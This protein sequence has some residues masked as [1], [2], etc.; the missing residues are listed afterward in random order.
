M[1]A[2]SHHEGA[3]RI[4]S[5]VTAVA[6]VVCLLLHAGSAPAQIPPGTHRFDMV[7]QPL[8]SALAEFA[9]VSGVDIAYRQSLAA[10]RRSRDVHGDYTAPVALQMLLEGTG[11]AARFTGPR[12]AIIFEPGTSEVSAPRRGTSATPSLRLGMA[13]VRA[14]VIVGTRNRTGHRQYAMVVQSEVR[15]WLRADRA[16]QGR[17][18]RLEIG[19]LVDPHGLIRQV[20]VR[21]PSSEAAW[22]EHVVRTLTGRSLSQPPP[23]DL[24]SPLAFEVSSDRPADRAPRRDGTRP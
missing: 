19:I 22:D 10:N 9:T 6:L 23:R 3:R 20:T 11:L 2:W 4:G 17:A 21:R 16:Y 14:P 12:A 15:E 1:K 18:F 8:A 5:T 13:E 24:S 7:P